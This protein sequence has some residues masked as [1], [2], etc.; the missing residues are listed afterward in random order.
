ML[1][2]LPFANFGFSLQRAVEPHGGFIE[3]SLVGG[4]GI[5]TLEQALAKAAPRLEDCVLWKVIRVITFVAELGGGDG[6]FAVFENAFHGSFLDGEVLC[7]FKRF[8]RAGQCFDRGIGHGDFNRLVIATELHVGGGGG[9]DEVAVALH[10]AVC[11]TDLG[12]GHVDFGP[13][14]GK[15][16]LGRVLRVDR[17]RVGGE[18]ER[19][20]EK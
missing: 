9:T 3:E 2:V 11:V 6:D 18:C 4:S 1:Y 5:E 14:V 19:Q 15:A 17:G 10:G 7:G 13:F 12:T 20:R 8:R 16:T